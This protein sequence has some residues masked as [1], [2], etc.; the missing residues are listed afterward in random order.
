MASASTIWCL[1]AARR[2]GAAAWLAYGTVD[3]VVQVV[4]LESDQPI[5]RLL[6]LDRHPILALTLDRD[7]RRLAIGDGQ[8][9]ITLV[10]AY[11]W[12]RARFSGNLEWADLGA[13]LHP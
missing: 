4:D 1:A 8:G 2:D 5:A 9:F 11:D 6:S 10:D 13:E 7:G 12:H 3:G